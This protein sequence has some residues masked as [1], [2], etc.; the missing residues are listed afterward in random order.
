[1]YEDSEQGKRYGELISMI[2]AVEKSAA[3]QT[4]TTSYIDISQTLEPLKAEP[5]IPFKETISI[6]SDIESSLLPQ[7]K[8]KATVVEQPKAVPIV[9]QPPQPLKVQQQQQPTQQQPPQQIPQARTEVSRETFSGKMANEE[10]A[11]KKELQDIVGRLSKYHADVLAATK[12]PEPPRKAMPPEVIEEQRP[13]PLAVSPPI[14][15]KPKLRQQKQEIVQPKQVEKPKVVQAPPTPP[16]IVQ[17]KVE[18][19][20]QVIQPLPET[21]PIIN[22]PKPQPRDKYKDNVMIRLPIAEQVSELD[23][24]NSG[25]RENVFNKDQ[26]S[27]IKQEIGGLLDFLERFPGTPADNADPYLASLTDARNQKV[28]EASRL[29]KL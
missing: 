28:L 20:K 17:Q 8:G 6:I 11:A 27:I 16:P 5:Q 24:I 18:A 22:L 29:L 26:L 3:T 15:I 4:Q 19:P 12:K 1:M 7:K 14:T 2:D 10:N 21:R 23:K 25:L 13:E 9:A